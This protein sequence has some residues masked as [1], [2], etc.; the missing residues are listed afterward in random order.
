MHRKYPE[1]IRAVLDAVR[2]AGVEWVRQGRVSPATFEAAAADICSRTE[3]IDTAN[4]F[5]DRELE[6]SKTR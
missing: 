5:W 1:R 2:T 6:R 3:L 4:A